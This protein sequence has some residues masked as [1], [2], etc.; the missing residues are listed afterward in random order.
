M[1]ASNAPQKLALLD[2]FVSMYASRV[3]TARQ[4]YM[5]KFIKVAVVTQVSATGRIVPDMRVEYLERDALLARLN[6]SQPGVVGAMSMF[7][8][9]DDGEVPFG[10]VFD[11]GDAIFMLIRVE[12]RER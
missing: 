10:L 5:S 12:L 11:D 2:A 9:A 8:R 3:E 7:D 1:L 4:E 6:T